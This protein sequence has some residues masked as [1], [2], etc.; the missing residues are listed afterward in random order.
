MNNIKQEKITKNRIKKKLVAG[1]WGQVT[2]YRKH[3]KILKGWQN[4]DKSRDME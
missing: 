3:T 1:G 4:K 2:F